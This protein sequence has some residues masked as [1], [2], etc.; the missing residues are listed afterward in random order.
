MSLLDSVAVRLDQ[1]PW[2]SLWRF[3]LGWFIVATWVAAT[4]DARRTAAFVAFFLAALLA[5]RLVPAVLRRLLPFSAS[6]QGIWAERR[7]LAKRFDSYQWQKLFWIGLGFTMYLSLSSGVS[8]GLW[9]LAFCCLA[10]G[11]SGLLIWQVRKT[12]IVAVAA[13]AA[14]K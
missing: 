5:V 6:T 9:P 2:A 8:G 14:R 7:Q 12:Q 4:R 3:A 1:A 13:S 11:A 10:S